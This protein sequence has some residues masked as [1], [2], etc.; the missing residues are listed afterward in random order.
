PIAT[1]P[2][3]GTAVNAEAPSIVSRINR[4]LSIARVCRAGGSSRS[5]RIG[6][7]EPMSLRIPGKRPHVKY[8]ALQ[9]GSGLPGAFQAAPAASSSDDESAAGVPGVAAPCVSV[10]VAVSRGVTKLTAQIAPV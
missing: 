8:F 6:R 10:A 3:P 9:R 1:P 7:T 2:Q 4:R 5:A